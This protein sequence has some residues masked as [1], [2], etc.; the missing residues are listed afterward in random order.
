VTVLVCFCTCPDPETA[1][2]IADALVEERLAACVNV[3]PG[4]RSVYRWK[5]AIECSDE[6]LL[7]VKTVAAQLRAVSARIV[8]LHPHELPEVIAVEASGGLGAYLDWVA[9]CSSEDPTRAGDSP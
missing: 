9:E 8:A 7:L 3:V 4:V 6:V 1:Q 2:R 5:G